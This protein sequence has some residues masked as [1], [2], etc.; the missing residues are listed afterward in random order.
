[1]ITPTYI[2]DIKSNVPLKCSI[3]VI[4]WTVGRQAL[5]LLHYANE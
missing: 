4:K 1:M 2:R 3:E 5:V